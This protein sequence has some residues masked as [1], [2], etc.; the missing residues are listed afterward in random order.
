MLSELVPLDRVS[1]ERLVSGIDLGS[2]SFHM[3]VARVEDTGRVHVLDR[4]REPVR[5]AAGFDKHN[6][7]TA[8]VIDRALAS[9]SRMGQRLKGLS[10]DSVRAVGTNALR[11][12]KNGAEFLEAAAAALGHP[13]EVISGHEEAR[14]IY[15]GVSHSSADDS[16]RHL[17]IDIGGGSTEL[18]IGERFEPLV[19]DSLYMGCVS[20]TERFFGNGAL[21]AGAFRKA[22]I[23]AGLELSSVQEQ[24]RR[25][26]WQRATGSSGTALAIYS[27]LRANRWADRITLAGLDKLK[28]AMIEQGRT[29]QLSLKG[30]EPDRAA[31]FPGGVAI[32][33]AAFEAL[34]IETM[35]VSNGA[36]REG[37]VYELLG[38]VAHEDVQKRTVRTFAER[39]KVDAVQAE[40]VAGTALGLL[41]Q[42]CGTWGLPGPTATVLLGTAARLHEVGLSIAYSGHHKHSAYILGNADMPGFSRDRQQ[43]LATLVRTHR[44]RFGRAL[45]RHLPKAQRRL[46][47]PLAVLLRLAVRLHHSR[48]D[49]PLP[50]IRVERDF[51][52][53]L[54]F[55][56]GWL[57]A[58]PLTRADFEAEAEELVAVDIE[59]SAS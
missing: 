22:E 30:L 32:L 56:A 36:L 15:L 21:S 59:L 2:N 42:V 14:L 58:H 17:V 8:E 3:V 23:A 28:A 25:V 10:A 57:D 6:R 19:L 52:L 24:Y 45:F 55:P 33:R 20:Y 54:E 40:R 18:I 4:I 37:L 46:A 16:G 48:T 5:L 1:S 11:R 51:A 29:Q 27:V 39:Y 53:K 47:L 43:I 12:A 41:D 26:A 34:G 50:R 49:A 35:G 9:L 31:V 13:I 38:R 7:M 44:R